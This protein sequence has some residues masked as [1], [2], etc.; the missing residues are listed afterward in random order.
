M[1]DDNIRIVYSQNYTATVRIKNSQFSD[2]ILHY[3]V[4]SRFLRLRLTI[5]NISSPF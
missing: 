3:Q 1:E 2:D 5:G 4:S